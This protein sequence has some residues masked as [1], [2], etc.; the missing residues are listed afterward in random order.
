MS[1]KYGVL[2]VPE[3]S[4]TALAYRARQLICGQFGSW[5][6]EMFMVH[7]TVADFFQCPDSAV[8]AVDAGLTG[9]AEQGRREAPQFL[10]SHRGVATFPDG[11][12][13]IFLDFN[14]PQKP[15]ALHTLHA[16]V[17]DLLQRTP[18]VTP[19]L[20]FAL[21]DYWPHLTL[22][23]YGNLLP[24]VFADAS[25]FAGAVVEDL[26]LPAATS[27]WRL[28]L[29]RFQSEAAGEDWGGGRWAADLRWVVTSSYG[30]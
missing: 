11:G 1:I 5:A 6:A 24:A 17:I 9:I 14:H 2:L 28:L 18:G 25:E 13:T 26:L 4:F 8:S 30:L 21:G 10:L 27:A 20:R 29:V 23:Q 3:P 22:M 19:D 15:L 12:G 7:L 16:S